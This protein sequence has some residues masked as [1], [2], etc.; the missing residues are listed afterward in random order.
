MGVGIELARVMELLTSIQM[1]VFNAQLAI[2]Y[3]NATQLNTQTYCE[4]T[5]YLS[6]DPGP[7]HTSNTWQKWPATWQTLTGTLQGILGIFPLSCWSTGAA[8]PGTR[9]KPRQHLALI[10]Q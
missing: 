4:K 9:M 1:K 7:G 8:P 6:P 10:V 2:R 5:R 3:K